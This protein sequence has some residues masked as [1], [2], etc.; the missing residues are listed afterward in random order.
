MPDYERIRAVAERLDYSP[1]TIRL[2][3]LKGYFPGAFRATGA[4]TEWR[5]PTGSKPE[6]QPA[7][8]PRRTV[9]KTR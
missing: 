1:E 7:K 9:R 2:W 3:C 8:A 4:G 5:I 6:F